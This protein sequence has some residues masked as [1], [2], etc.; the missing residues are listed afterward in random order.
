MRLVDILTCRDLSDVDPDLTPPSCEASQLKAYLA[1]LLRAVKLG[2]VKNDAARSFVDDV[3]SVW[4][5]TL[6]ARRVAGVPDKA[7]LSDVSS[8]AIW[9]G[10][11]TVLAA[12]SGRLNLSHMGTLMCEGRPDVPTETLVSV[13]DDRA[14]SF[15]FE[16]PS[17][18][19]NLEVDDSELMPLE[20]RLEEIAPRDVVALIELF[21]RRLHWKQDAVVGRPKSVIWLTLKSSAVGQEIEA[22]EKAVALAKKTPE[23]ADTILR[24]LKSA[25]EVRNRLGLWS[26]PP[27]RHGIAVVFKRTYTQF[28]KDDTTRAK[29]PTIF[30]AAGYPRFRHWPTPEGIV[31]D[32]MG[33]GRT[34][35][36]DP[37]VR[38]RD[39]PSDGAPEI[40]SPPRPLDEVE[41]LVYLGQFGPAPGSGEMAA[42]R[43]ACAEFA[44]AI[45][46]SKSLTEIVDEISHLLNV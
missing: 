33:R 30:D 22:A 36:L 3:K 42:E 46:G 44:A 14:F 40:V 23:D 7:D 8:E 45:A 28:I 39:R 1:C 16:A 34:Y 32:P 18:N 11:V 25:S 31:P 6:A 41:S 12:F 27:L 20:A 10:F 29:A 9:S 26:N 37:A 38:D 5:E 15:W 4:L 24:S 17:A 35:E 19:D 21:G 43:K 2:H 13:Q